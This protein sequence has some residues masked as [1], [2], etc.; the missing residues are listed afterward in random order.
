M[1]KHV[2]SVI[3]VIFGGCGSDTPS[4]DTDDASN[5]TGPD[6][7]QA[8]TEPGSTNGS[9]S[10]TSTN[11]DRSTGAE[12]ETTDTTGAGGVSCECLDEAVCTDFAGRLPPPGWTLSYDPADAE[13]ALYYFTP[14]GVPAE[15]LPYSAMPCDD[16]AVA[17]ALQTAQAGS[18]SLLFSPSVPVP[19]GATLRAGSRFWL[20]SDL[21]PEVT[22]VEFFAVEVPLAG[23]LEPWFRAS[24]EISHD[25]L[26]LVLEEGTTEIADATVPQ[27][28]FE[29]EWVD[30]RIEV[31]L[32]ANTAIAVV[33]DALTISADIP[34]LSPG[35]DSPPT[36]RVVVG[37]RVDE[38]AISGSFLFDTASIETE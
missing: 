20:E 21:S 26:R 37:P 19:P 31:D 29:R 5:S 18:H 32:S 35:S 25:Q 24:L 15:L 30:L 38:N 9:G 23:S 28:I 10:G 11:G 14:D 33:N 17:T 22:P 1:Q 6:E 2:A 3:F 16:W 13:P 7:S 34:P 27:P 12:E 36:A 8:T 4:G